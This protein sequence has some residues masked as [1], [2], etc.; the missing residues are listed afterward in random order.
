[1]PPSAE[2][3]LVVQAFDT[4]KH[5]DLARAIEQLSPDEAAFFLHKLEAAIRKRKLQITGYLVAMGAWLVGMTLALIYFGMNDG[6]TL[7]VF[8][9]PFGIVGVILYGFGTWA[10]RV[11]RSRPPAARVVAS[12]EA[13]RSP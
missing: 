7:W 13:P 1:V 5:E 2:D 8:V 10:E 11:G 6:F 3:P 12:D 4:R 9:V